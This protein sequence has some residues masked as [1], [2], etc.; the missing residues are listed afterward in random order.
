MLRTIGI[1]I[2][3][4]AGIGPEV[5][6]K[7]VPTLRRIRG[8]RFIIFTPE[9]CL[10]RQ[11]EKLGMDFSLP[12]P[13]SPAKYP[14]K[15][16]VS[17]VIGPVSVHPG[18]TNAGTGRA[19]FQL[20]AIAIHQALDGKIDA[21]VTAPVC[22]HAINRAGIP[23]TGHTEMLR[24][25]TGAEDMLM[26]FVSPRLKAGLVTT[27]LPVQEI[28]QNLTATGILSKLDLMHDGLKRYF[29]IRKPSIGVAS[30][31]PHAGEAG[32][33]GKEELSII[34]PAVVRAR[35]RGLDA[36]GPFPPDTILLK[37]DGFD[38]LLFM[39]HDQ[40]MIAVKM[41]AWGKN[42][43]VTLGLPFVRTSPDHGTGLDIAGRGIASPASFIEAI[44]LACTMVRRSKKGKPGRS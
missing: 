30:L 37:R 26:L 2:G 16:V 22:K 12:P 8:F 31:N 6:L 19:A 18:R 9:R 25:L 5:V 24:D 34:K 39:Y 23:F 38:A 42:V 7:S 14:K 36:A 3:E 35:K 20:I 21:L 41:L 10:P 11:A 40:A 33:L 28:P 44:K 29:G 17:E 4:P 32:Y 1:T 15:V 43:N 27:H 13:C